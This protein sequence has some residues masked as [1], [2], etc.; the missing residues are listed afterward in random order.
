VTVRAPTTVKFP[1]EALSHALRKIA[2]H[3]DKY[4]IDRLSVEFDGSM[5]RVSF[6]GE[7]IPIT[8][9][10]LPERDTDPGF[11]DDTKPGIVFD[12]KGRDTGQ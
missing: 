12:R 11:Q 6:N 5:Y 9:V 2:E 1:R 4:E 10:G 7:G 8:I 3:A